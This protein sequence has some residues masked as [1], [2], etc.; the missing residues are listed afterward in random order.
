VLVRTCG[1]AFAM[2]GRYFKS[3]PADYALR[4]VMAAVAFVTMFHPDDTLV[5]GTAAVVLTLLLF[6]LWRHRQVAPPEMP[7][8]TQAGEVVADQRETSRLLVEGQRDIG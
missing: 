4:I 6:G 2:F 7:L 3:P 8:A 5:W 1:I